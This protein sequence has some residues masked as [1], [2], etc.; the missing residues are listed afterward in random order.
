MAPA[1]ACASARTSVMDPKQGVGREDGERHM[2]DALSWRSHLAALSHL[3]PVTSCHECFRDL[4][5]VGRS[6]VRIS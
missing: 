6:G 2:N 5:N 1:F 4:H 3:K